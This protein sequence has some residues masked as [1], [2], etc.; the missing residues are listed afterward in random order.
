MR[1]HQPWHR[2]KNESMT[3]F[4]AFTI[5]KNIPFKDRNYKNAASEIGLSVASV[6]A[7]GA[8]N[9][10]ISRAEAW[11]E[12]VIEEEDKAFHAERRLVVRRHAATSRKMNDLVTSRLGTMDP[13][14][15]AARDIPR[16]LDTLV[17]VERLSH[18][19]AT[20]RIIDNEGQGRRGDIDL[21][22]LSDDDLEA[23]ERIMEKAENGND[24][25]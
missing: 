13:D 6:S 20:D 9:N 16:F 25:K 15:I 3:S 12:H 5:Y 17:K 23:L 21:S 18:D 22:K 1:N 2:L 19:M 11:D 24:G 7:M 14:E 10:W 8:K 4:K